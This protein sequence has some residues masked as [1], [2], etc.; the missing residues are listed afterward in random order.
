MNKNLMQHIAQAL[1]PMTDRH[2]RRELEQKAKAGADA[3]K[4]VKAHNE[5]LEAEVRSDDPDQ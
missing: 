5:Q 1:E 2:Q 3:L 4:A